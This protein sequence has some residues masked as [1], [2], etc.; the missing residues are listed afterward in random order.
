MCYQL[1]ARLMDLHGDQLPAAVDELARYGHLMRVCQE[2]RQLNRGASAASVDAVTKAAASNRAGVRTVADADDGTVDMQQPAVQEV[3]LAQGPVMA[4]VGRLRALLADWP[5]NPLLLQLLAIAERLLSLPLAAPL[6]QALTGVE[7][8]LARAQVR[9]C[10]HA[11]KELGFSRL[12]Q[13]GL[14]QLSYKQAKC[15]EANGVVH[16]IRA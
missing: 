10:L 4:V 15:Y 9:N 7:L 13:L 16:S 2:H 8:L 11:C 1:G 12:L 5:D 14:W 3:S 6:K